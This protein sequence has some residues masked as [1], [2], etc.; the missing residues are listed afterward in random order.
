MTGGAGRHY[1]I[2]TY[3]GAVYTRSWITTLGGLPLLF[4][5]YF[6]VL[7]GTDAWVVVMPLLMVVVVAIWA[8][9]LAVVGNDGIRLVLQR[10]SVAWADVAAVLEPRAGDETVRLALT[11]GQILPV[12]GVPPQAALALRVVHTA[13]R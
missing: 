1:G 4:A 13:R 8:V 2:G 7:E 10:R 12:P 3:R 6:S 5:A 11:D 9:P